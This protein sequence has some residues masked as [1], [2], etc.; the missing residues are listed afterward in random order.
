MEFTNSI[1]NRRSVYSLTNETTIPNAKIVEIVSTATKHAPSPMN[2]QSQM[3]VLLLGKNHLQLWDIVMESL[4]KIV[5]PEKFQKTE[6]KINTFK[7]GFGTVLYFNDDSITQA[8]QEKYPTYTEKFATWAEQASAMLQFAIWNMLE[9]EGLG[10][11]LQH[12]N[13][14]I[15]QAVLAEF[16]LPATWRLIAQ[17]P[18]G[19]PFAPPEEKTF[20]PIEQRVKIFE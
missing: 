10:A 2:C 3:T 15:D 19:K 17:M 13:P 1:K 4:R 7:A 11:S 5:K 14:I 20:L 9:N 18:F 6:D 16:K 8:L 12:Y